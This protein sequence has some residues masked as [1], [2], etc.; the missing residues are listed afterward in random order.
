MKNRTELH[1]DGICLYIDSKVGAALPGKIIL[2]MANLIGWTLFLYAALSIP[3]EYLRDFIFPMIIFFLI[4]IFILGRYTLWNLW[5]AEF[6]RIN[7][8]SLSYF[9]SYGILQ[10][11]EKVIKLKTPGFRY[12][13]I[14]Y[15]ED[16]EH[17]IL[18][19][20]D[21]DDLDNPFEIFQTTVLISKLK[22][23]EIFVILK[24]IYNPEESFDELKN[25]I[26]F[27]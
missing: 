14:R 20:C 24:K 25:I 8:K 2:I 17:G 7:N 21:Y 3:G 11:S 12:E 6:I 26:S 10:T 18:F 9:R 4:L 27:N 19:I 22:I 13:K 16:V 5:G 23:D 1:F 15:F